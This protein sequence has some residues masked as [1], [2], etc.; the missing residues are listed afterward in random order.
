MELLKTSIVQHV[1]HHISTCSTSRLQIHV[2]WATGKLPFWYGQCTL[3]GLPLHS[4]VPGMDLEVRCQDACMRT[5]IQSTEPGPNTLTGTLSPTSTLAH[6]LVVIYHPVGWPETQLVS[7][8]HRLIWKGD[9]ISVQSWDKICYPI[10]NFNEALW[11]SIPSGNCKILLEPELEKATSAGQ[12]A[13]EHLR[14]NTY[15]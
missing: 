8:A 3:G 14:D 10:P 9:M 12:S 5:C 2:P 7:F 11:S 15:Q 1:V 13:I 4:R 6:R